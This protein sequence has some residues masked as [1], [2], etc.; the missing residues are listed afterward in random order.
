[1]SSGRFSANPHRQDHFIVLDEILDS[2]GLAAIFTRLEPA[3]LLYMEYFAGKNPGDASRLYGCL[4]I[5]PS[6]AMALDQL[7][8]AYICVTCRLFCRLENVVAKNF[9]FV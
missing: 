3:E 2:S 5:C 4:I 9:T 7:G 8:T 1:M 6:I